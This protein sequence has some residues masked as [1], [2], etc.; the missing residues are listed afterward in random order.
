MYYHHRRLAVYSKKK[1]G[2]KK[3][4]RKGKQEGKQSSGRAYHA[5]ITRRGHGISKQQKSTKS[6]KA[7]Q[8]RDMASL[9]KQ[10]KRRKTL[11]PK[12]LLLGNRIEQDKVG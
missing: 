7:E 6:K 10:S 11:T 1:K 3:G 5:S 9:E 2:I 12:H 8:E 4:V